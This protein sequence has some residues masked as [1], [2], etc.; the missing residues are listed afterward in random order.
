MSVQNVMEGIRIN[1]CK[2]VEL[3]KGGTSAFKKKK[4]LVTKFF[5]WLIN[6]YFAPLLRNVFTITES[7]PGR[8]HLF[9]YR[10]DVW[11]K[12]QN[13]GVQE[14]AKILTPLSEQQA[15]NFLASGKSLGYAPLRFTPKTRYD[16]KTEKN[17]FK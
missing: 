5:V 14:M 12:A 7:K 16:V 17:E 15:K 9:Y 3:K 4:G 10:N 13:A 8:N 6:V 1:Q 11:Q 2:F